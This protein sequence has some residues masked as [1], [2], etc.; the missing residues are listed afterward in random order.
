MAQA[1]LRT[2]IIE[3]KT[4]NKKIAELCA[5]LK[6]LRQRKKTLEE[7]VLGYM[8]TT[9]EQGLLEIKMADVNITAVEKTKRER[10]KKD[11]KEDKAMQ[12]LIRSGVANPGKVFKELQ[13]TMKGKE[14]KT[15]VLKLKERGK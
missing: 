12:L 10:L 3:L 7:Q 13:D 4:I 14:A 1:K 2:D 9:G 8:K 15:Q 11:E 5:S 6:P